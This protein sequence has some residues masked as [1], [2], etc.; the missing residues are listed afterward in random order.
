MHNS[1]TRNDQRISQSESATKL[2][3]Y[4]SKVAISC[5][6]SLSKSNAKLRKYCNAL[7]LLPYLQVWAAVG[8]SICEKAL[9]VCKSALELVRETILLQPLYDDANV[10]TCVPFMWIYRSFAALCLRRSCVC[11]IGSLDLTILEE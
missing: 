8:A 6:T 11:W 2:L 3:R 7:L 10:A 4:Q 9:N 1:Y 5:N